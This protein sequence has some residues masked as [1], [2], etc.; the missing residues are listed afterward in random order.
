MSVSNVCGR[1]N[2][3]A[4]SLEYLRR[5]LYLGDEGFVAKH[6]PGQRLKEV[7]LQ[8]ILAVRPQLSILSSRKDTQSVVVAE[9]YR[10][11]GYRM[12]EI[13]EFLRIHYSTVSRRI[14]QVEEERA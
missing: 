8:Q 4:G 6:Q 13:D 11:Y 5:Q 12:R 9:A 2:R 10:T 3:Q 14:R 1:G 7:S